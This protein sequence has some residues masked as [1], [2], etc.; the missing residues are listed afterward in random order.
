MISLIRLPPPASP[1]PPCP[2]AD[3]NRAQ[4]FMPPPRMM[5]PGGR[6]MPMMGFPPQQG[7]QQRQMPPRPPCAHPP[8]PWPGPPLGPLGPKPPYKSMDAIGPYGRATSRGT[9]PIF[10]S[11]LAS[12][13]GLGPGAPKVC[14]PSVPGP[15]GPWGSLQGLPWGALGPQGPLAPQGPLGPGQCLRPW[16]IVPVDSTRTVVPLTGF[17]WRGSGG[18]LYLVVRISK[19]S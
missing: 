14:R 17:A 8:P 18:K 7:F 12:L 15:S 5:L 9:P 19:S 13:S 2:V 16:T 11:T 6:G 3:P 4:G 10:Q 1:S